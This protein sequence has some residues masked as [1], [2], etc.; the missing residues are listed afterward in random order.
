MKKIVEEMINDAIIRLQESGNWNSFDVPLIIVD[1]PKSIVHGDWT[2]NVC[3]ILA[4]I[5]Q[6]SPLII[7]EELSAELHVEKNNFIESI[8]AISPG[9]INF[10]LQQSVLIEELQKINEKNDSYGN[11]N[12]LNG[13]AIMI[14]YTQPNPFKPFHI[15]HLMSNTIGESLSRIIAF[16]GANVI[17]A[18]YQ[19]DVGPHV[20]KSLWAIQK[21]GYDITNI[22]EIGKAYAKG[23]VAYETDET[24][25]KEIHAINKAI[26]TCS[27]DDLMRLYAIGRSRTLERFEEIYAILGT[28][29]DVYYFESDTWKRGERIVREHM[30]DIFEESEGAIIFDGE[31]YGLHKRVFI[32]TQGLPTYEAKDVGLAMIK[33][34]TYPSD[35]YIITT[36][37]EQEEYFKV[38]KKAIELIDPSFTGKLTHIAHGMMQLTTGKM[39]SRKG[40]VITGES[41]ITDAQTVAKAKMSER[42][43]DDMQDATVNMIAVAGIK[44]NILKQHTGKNI[45]YDAQSALSFDGDSGPYVQYTY[46]RCRSVITKAQ[47]EK[48]VPHWSESCK[49]SVELERTLVQFP[50][51]VLRA[52]QDHAP[53][54]IANYVIDCARLFNAFYATTT[55]IDKSDSQKTAYRVAVTMA[56]AQIIKNSLYLLGIQTPEKM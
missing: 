35:Q 55:I 17:R 54:Y 38:I 15:G 21:F 13:Q 22:D 7:M 24:A 29:F 6:R 27:N 49:N 41:L 26:Y 45:M 50:E 9:Y 8:T 36:A 5:L 18:N 23:H 44:F 32:T 28:K 31:K 39:S 34:E 43:M 37:V 2:T 16:S 40:N 56:T 47:N 20:A 12:A 46:A 19:G 25:K 42:A 33:K 10:S 11:N 3:F 53:H 52:S 14:E 1:R 51:V 30:G 48:I 4:K